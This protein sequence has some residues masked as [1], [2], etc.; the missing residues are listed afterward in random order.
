M[1][2]N[3]VPTATKQP[4]LEAIR[5][6]CNGPHGARQFEVIK[7]TGF[8]RAYICTLLGQ[9]VA[10]GHLFKSGT[11]NRQRYY[12]T[13]PARDADADFVARE[14]A[15]Y[16]ERKRQRYAK[17][18]KPT[19]S[20]E[21]VRAMLIKSAGNG[22]SEKEAMAE[23]GILP[24]TVQKA[25]AKLREGGELHTFRTN[26]LVRFF[27]TPE[28]A[29]A[30]AQVV[31]FDREEKKKAKIAAR[32]NSPI[33]LARREQRNAKA[34][35]AYHSRKAKEEPSKAAVK[36]ASRTPK[37]GKELIA[38]HTKGTNAIHIPTPKPAVEVIIPE[39]VKRTYIPAPAG[40]FDV[41][42][43]VIGGFATMGPGQ[44]LDLPSRFT[45]LNAR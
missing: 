26:N 16:Q 34:K 21:K 31:T 2:G 40:R 10:A 13:K 30:F 17:K 39:N 7:A 36:R 25:V 14:E 41:S 23:F 42:G 9:Y 1:E 38:S 28:Y 19:P 33:A 27:S 12:S 15:E 44:Y 3:T 35:A 8:Q 22:I 18:E 29:K 43:P 11:I 20:L 24:R 6:C 37:T 5:N 32:K 4:R 45:Y